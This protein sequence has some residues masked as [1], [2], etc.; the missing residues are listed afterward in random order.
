MKGVAHLRVMESGSIW[1]LVTMITGDR[2]KGKR[3]DLLGVVSNVNGRRSK[4]QFY[5]YLPCARYFPY[6]MVLVL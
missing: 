1:T 4:S 2:V 6:F 3:R 5:D